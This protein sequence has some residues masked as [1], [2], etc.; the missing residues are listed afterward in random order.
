MVTKRGIETNPDQI[1]VLLA[2]SSPRNIHEVQ[3][4]NGRVAIFI[5]FIS[6]STDK[7]LP[8]FKILRKNRAFEWTDEFEV[9]FKQVKEHLGSPPLL[10]VLTT[11][12]DLIVYLSI[13]PTA[14]SVML[15]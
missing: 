9:A 1:Q 8:F 11:G 5:R 14:S 12:E 7:C 6:K 13:L 3:Q 10:T 4:L 2:M 15:I